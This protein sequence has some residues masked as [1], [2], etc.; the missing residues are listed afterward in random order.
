GSPVGVVG[1][2]N[3]LKIHIA[4]DVL[5]R[6]TGLG[7]LAKTGKVVLAGTAKEAIEKI[8]QGDILVVYETD[9][10]WMPAI[11]KACAI[12]T[13]HGGLTSH[14]A[15]V[16]LNLGIPVIV[17]AEDALSILEDGMIVTVDCIRGQIYK[18][19]AKVL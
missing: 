1:T 15:I 6:G 19:K 5:I 9:L 13:E 11:D 14:A 7:K 8:N 3:L 10:D 17:G 16:G 4:G 2:T 12:I 18:G